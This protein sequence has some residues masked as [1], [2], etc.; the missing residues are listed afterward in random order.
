MYLKYQNEI[1]LAKKKL[2]VL[3]FILEKDSDYKATFGNGTTWKIDVNGKWYD[4]YCYISIRNESLSDSKV[5][6]AGFPLWMIMKMFGKDPQLKTTEDK[7]NFIIEYKD[8]IFDEKFAYKKI[9]DE[10]ENNI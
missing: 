7:L 5:G 6:K 10:L 1:N 9:Y 8:K 3:N 4:D 2:L